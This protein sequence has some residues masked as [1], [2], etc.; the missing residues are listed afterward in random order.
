M[1]H[2]RRGKWRLIKK[3][4]AGGQGSVYLAYD[5]ESLQISAWDA[6]PLHSLFAEAQKF[7]NARSKGRQVAEAATIRIADRPDV[8]DSI[9][10]LLDLAGQVRFGALKQLRPPGEWTRDP[11]HAKDRLVQEIDILGAVK[12][13]ALIRVLDTDKDAPWLVTEY[14]PRG[15]LRAN[16]HLFN[17]QPLLALAAIRGLASGIAELHAKEIIHRDIKPENVFV[18]TDGRL[19]LGDFGLALPSDAERHTRTGD[20][21]GTY[22]WMPT[23]AMNVKHNFM[24]KFDIYAI[25]KLLLYL[26]SDKDALPAEYT[27]GDIRQFVSDERAADAI[28]HVI[29][30]C[31]VLNEKDCLPSVKTL[32]AEIDDASEAATAPASA[33]HLKIAAH[34]VG[35]PGPF[36]LLSA[37]A[38]KKGRG[39]DCEPQVNW[40]FSHPSAYGHGLQLPGVFETGAAPQP[41]IPDENL[42]PHFVKYDNDCG[43]WLVSPPEPTSFDNR[44][45]FQFD[46]V[47]IRDARFLQFA[48]R[49]DSRSK[50]KFYLRFND[51]RWI[52]YSSE[53]DSGKSSDYPE[54]CIRDSR[55]APSDSIHFVTRDLRKDLEHTWHLE[56][57]EPS[58]VE[59]VRLRGGFGLLL[60]RII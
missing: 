22:P 31:V 45:E 39:P 9:A 6:E 28:E 46:P 5:E 41:A 59:A 12:H 21:A 1:A 60:V 36:Y 51:N 29:R 18:G 40:K 32:L 8:G 57:V 49:V 26:L 13:P 34:A 52:G 24:P 23:W 25:G 2:D 7:S 53:R 56:G 37:E 47:P 50:F 27:H 38:S 48:I 30:Q 43:R 19:I 3:L 17:G 10:T 35:R 16:G 20:N 14:H 58:A 11:E 15:S 54:Y 33:L 42:W 4:G 55:L 44:I